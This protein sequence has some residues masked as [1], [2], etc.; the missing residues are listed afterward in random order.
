VEET[1]RL[2]DTD[3]DGKADSSVHFGDYENKGGFQLHAAS[4]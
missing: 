2:R 4:Q 3:G 1:W